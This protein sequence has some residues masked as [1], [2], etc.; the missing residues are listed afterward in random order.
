MIFKISD[1]TISTK[2][3][4]ISTIN[5]S[6]SA[7]ALAL[8][9]AA[10]K[11]LRGPT[12]ALRARGPD[13]AGTTASGTSIGITIANNSSSHITITIKNSAIS[14][15]TISTNFT[16]I[17]SDTTNATNISSTTG[18]THQGL[19]GPFGPRGPA[20]AELVLVV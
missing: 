5:C 4:A 14:N 9:L 19:P 16:S 12:L 17:I 1:N 3:S 8:L 13:V 7:T 18:A 15:T 6:T 11:L 10:A 20:P 2:N